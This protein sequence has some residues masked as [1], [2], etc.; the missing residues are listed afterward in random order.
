MKKNYFISMLLCSTLG[1]F[2]YFSTKEENYNYANELYQ[3]YLEGSSIGYIKNDE[4]L[5]N[6]INEEQKEIKDLYKVNN[7]YPPSDFEIIKVNSYENKITKATDIYSMIENKDNFTVKGYEITISN[8]DEKNKIETKIHVLDKKIFENVIDSFVDAYID[9][10]LYEDYMNGEQAEILNT[11]FVITEMDFAESISIQE[12]FVSVNEKIYTNEA[13]LLQYLIFGSD[14]K[15]MDYEI[16][17]GDS[18]ETIADDNK[19]NISEFLISN[20]SY[21]DEN[22]MLQI[23]EKVNVTLQNPVLNFV[24]KV[25]EVE[26]VETDY[27][28]KT[29][30]DNTKASSYSE[31]TTKG[32]TGLNLVTME[33]EV[34]N[35]IESQEVVVLESKEIRPVVNQ[36]TTKGVY[37]YSGG[38]TSYGPDGLQTGL[39]FY[40]P[41]NPGFIVTAPFGQWR[42]S[43][44]HM[45]VDISGTGYG[46]NIYAIAD[47]VVTQAYN[48]G[49]GGGAWEY[50][51]FV[52]ISHGNNYYS[53]YMHMV[54]GS[55]K[56]NV[57]Q[58]V[59]GGQLI[60]SMGSTGKSTGTH[61]HLGFSIGEP[62][63]GSVTYYDAYKLIF[64]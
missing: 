13:E 20:P 58:K 55:L 33:Y 10:S 29:V 49:L 37:H 1:I 63:R 27:V 50:G 8:N 56:V 14:A 21:R 36:V 51:T 9:D 22:T 59:S 39:T 46:S 30:Y 43:Y 42:G 25:K 35:G 3:V 38:S 17:A 40:S 12:S 4:E 44:K 6:L 32:V 64:R 18:I 45:G 48:Y 15:I 28:N 53:I 5:Y 61:L 31:V 2:Y 19:L 41:V 34:T 24:Y 60:G 23:G 52:V 16:K 7:V 62:N 26:E 11:G 57:G 47:G 54:Q